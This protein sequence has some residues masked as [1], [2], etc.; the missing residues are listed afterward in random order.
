MSSS[1][2]VGIVGAGGYTG[3]EL[4]RLVHGHPRLDLVWVAA[5][6]RAGQ[7]LAD[8]VPTVRG[9][10]GLGD[11]VLEAFDP[12]KAGEIARRIDVAFTALPHGASTLVVRSLLQ[13]GVRVVDLS[14]DFRL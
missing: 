2:R 9:V 13:A 8:A 12:A 7:K 14:A 3:A 10:S 1:L 5:N 4:V 6:Q 11:L